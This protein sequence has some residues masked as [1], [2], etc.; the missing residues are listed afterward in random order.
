MT[1]WHPARDARGARL[2]AAAAL[3]R[4]K[5]VAVPDV[6]RLLEIVLRSGD[7]VCIEGD[8]QKQAD[9]LSAA[10]VAVDV[11]KVNGLHMVQSGVVLPEHLDLF[12][13]GVAQR[14]DFAY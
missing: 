14:L 9:V 7:R 12:E 2:D 13:R 10:L 1:S 5:I 3:A 6:T 11:S 4:G 8:N